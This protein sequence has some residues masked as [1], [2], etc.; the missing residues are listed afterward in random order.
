[1]PWFDEAVIDW[2]QQTKSKKPPSVDEIKTTLRKP[3]PE[4]KRTWLTDAMDLMEWTDAM[5]KGAY[6]SRKV[7]VP[8]YDPM[9]VVS[10]QLTAEEVEAILTKTEIARTKKL[11]PRLEAMAVERKAIELEIHEWSRVL[12]AL[13][14]TSG[15]EVPVRKSQLGIARRIAD[16][17]AETLGIDGPSLPK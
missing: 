6:P 1:L 9:T 12:L 17:L 4:R 11:R 14:G 15:K 7:A 3:F 2:M 16:H 10:I 8:S 13:C 5:C